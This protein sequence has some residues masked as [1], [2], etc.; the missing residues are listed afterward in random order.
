MERANK[1]NRKRN[2]TTFYIILI[3]LFFLFGSLL[4]TIFPNYI[5]KRYYYLYN[6]KTN[7]IFQMELFQIS[8][9]LTEISEEG[10]ISIPS[11]VRLFIS[12]GTAFF[13]SG[14]HSNSHPDSRNP[15]HVTPIPIIALHTQDLKLVFHLSQT[16][17]LNAMNYISLGNSETVEGIHCQKCAKL[18]LLKVADF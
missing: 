4:F 1:F 9:L 6:W 7:F 14:S 12:N 17:I 3:Q 18:S 10:L 11:S 16:N 15:K 13:F 5:F 8:Q 2:L